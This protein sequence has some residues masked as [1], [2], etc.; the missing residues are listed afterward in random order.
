MF[1]GFLIAALLLCA[2][3]LSVQL[4]KGCVLLASGREGRFGMVNCSA[5]MCMEL[6]LIRFVLLY[7]LN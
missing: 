6:G 5:L 7:C 2:P 3:V 4:E 1:R